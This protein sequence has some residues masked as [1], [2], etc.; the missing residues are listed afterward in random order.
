MLLGQVSPNRFES[1]R[2][3]ADAGYYTPQLAPTAFYSNFSPFRQVMNPMASYR[4]RLP[5]LPR[6][7]RPGTLGP[8]MRQP[9][10]TQPG[11][12]PAMPVAP[13]QLKGGFNFFGMGSAGGQSSPFNFVETDP[14]RTARTG[15]WLNVPSNAQGV[16]AGVTQA[17]AFLQ[18]MYPAS[19]PFSTAG[20]Y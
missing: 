14:S 8:S 18:R 11:P 15:A 16:R 10:P 20:R 7:I 4:P 13:E 2:R 5:D 19:Y 1:F 12:A 6:A 9:F 17:G 3:P